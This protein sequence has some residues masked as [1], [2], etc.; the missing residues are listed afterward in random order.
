M[1]TAKRVTR[2]GAYRQESNKTR[3]YYIGGSSGRTSERCVVNKTAILETLDHPDKIREWFKLDKNKYNFFYGIGSILEAKEKSMI[4]SINSIKLELEKLNDEY[5]KNEDN[6]RK[7]VEE[8]QKTAPTEMKEALQESIREKLNV[9][10]ESKFSSL[11]NKK[12]SYDLVRDSIVNRRWFIVDALQKNLGE[13]MI[14]LIQK[15]AEDIYTFYRGRKYT[16]I[17]KR[18]YEMIITIANAPESFQAS[19]SLNTSIVGPAGSGKTTMAK[20]IAKWYAKLGILTY[21]A[22]FENPDKLSLSETARTDFIGEYTGQTGPKTLGVLVKSLEKTLFIDEAY[23]V[24]GCAFDKDDKL[25]ADAYGEEF[26]ATLLTF[27]NDHKGFNAIIVAGYENLMKKCFMERNEG[28]PRRFPVQITLP[29]YTTDELF[30]IFLFNVINKSLYSLESRNE[31]LG[32]LI[33]KNTAAIEDY[34]GK[35]QV[36]VAKPVTSQTTQEKTEYETAITALGLKNKQMELEKTRLQEEIPIESVYRSRYLAVIK[37]SFMMIHYDT[38]HSFVEILRKYLVLIQLRINLANEMNGLTECDLAKLMPQY[39]DSPQS[40]GEPIKIKRSDGSSTPSHSH[41]RPVTRAQAVAAQQRKEEKKET[42]SAATA[43]AAAAAAAK[44]PVASAEEY[45]LGSPPRKHGARGEPPASAPPAAAAPPPA[46]APPAAAAPPPAS[47][48]PAA[49][50]PPASA[51]PAASAPQRQP[52]V[53]INLKSIYSYTII[54]HVLTNLL[55]DDVI[56]VRKHI[57]RRLFYKAVFNFEG[58]NMSFFPAQAGEMDNLA[59][60]C[61]RSTATKIP[62]NRSKPSVDICEEEK[63][64][65]TYCAGKKI[66]VNLFVNIDSQELAEADTHA[67]K[68]SNIAGLKTELES[69]KDVKK[70][71]RIWHKLKEAEATAKSS[72]SI[73]TDV[74]GKHFMELISTNFKIT[75]MQKR[76]ADFLDLGKLFGGQGIPSIGDFYES[77][78]HGPTLDKYT[79][80]VLDLYLRKANN[81]YLEDISMMGEKS[82][83]I[84]IKKEQLEAEI[85]VLQPF[86]ALIALEYQTEHKQTFS[87]EMQKKINSNSDP[88]PLN[89]LKIDYSVLEQEIRD[90]TLE[91]AKVSGEAKVKLISELKDL[92]KRRTS[93]IVA[94]S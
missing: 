28:L 67:D 51:P 61:S 71:I 11:I 33:K 9:A 37:P 89:N 76:I 80:H 62:E 81:E 20:E 84:H 49:A 75:D 18:L 41:G 35:I 64:I 63:L 55:N 79:E 57:F 13:D 12:Q 2:R 23:S 26:L 78:H 36:L 90:K 87:S 15:A 22:F 59:D 56:S 54:N 30:G 3:H 25:E 86:A 93:E 38:S 69:E 31:L 16:T 72:S 34:K 46:S 48:P 6:Y 7:L 10:Y 27:M 66:A 73:F 60:E 92:V 53:P 68:V 52:G 83:P 50:A 47:A 32:G 39:T 5:N 1:H 43:A 24:A 94:G 85:Q 29:F 82:Y 8:S 14:N 74:T 42:R 65:N 77:L 4:K 88:T 58:S 17:R 21:D 45:P 91:A 40:G 44:G 70:K 19:F